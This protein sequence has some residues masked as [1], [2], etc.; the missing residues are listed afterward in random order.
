MKHP[1]LPNRIPAFPYFYKLALSAK[2]YSVLLY[3]RQTALIAIT[4]AMGRNHHESIPTL[5]FTG[6]HDCELADSQP[7]SDICPGWSIAVG[8]SQNQP[9]SDVRFC[10]RSE[11]ITVFFHALDSSDAF[12]GLCDLDGGFCAWCGGFY[13]G[14]CRQNVS[15]SIPHVCR[16]L[17]TGKRPRTAAE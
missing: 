2:H 8:L 10:H 17:W 1:R 16:I 5:K 14:L 12:A 11:R 9:D 6:Y 3:S 13:L 15:V 7:D 4:T